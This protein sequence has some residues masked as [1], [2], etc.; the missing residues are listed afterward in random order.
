MRG[1]F[2][3]N[4]DPRSNSSITGVTFTNCSESCQSR[5]NTG[6][7]VID[8]RFNVHYNMAP[9]I[10][11][12]IQLLLGSLRI[13]PQESVE[14]YLACHNTHE[15]TIH[16]PSAGRGLS[17]ISWG[18]NRMDVFAENP[19]SGNISHKYWDGYQWGPTVQTLEDLG[20]PSYALGGSPGAISRNESLIEYV[21]FSVRIF[22]VR[23]HVYKKTDVEPF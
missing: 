8:Q 16:S 9:F 7:P 3:G 23:W 11:A 18:F 15:K 17:A 14:Q 13:R 20:G 22:V 4:G 12:T 5:A 1:S 10:T 21:Q 19:D 2:V 6:C